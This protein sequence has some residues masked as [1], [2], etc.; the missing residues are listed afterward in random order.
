VWPAHTPRDHLRV[1]DVRR[2][3]L[4]WYGSLCSPN[5][6]QGPS[7]CIAVSCDVV[8]PSKLSCAAAEIM[9]TLPEDT[10]EIISTTEEGAVRDRV[11]A[12]FIVMAAHKDSLDKWLVANRSTVRFDVA[13]KLCKQF[14]DVRAVV[15]VCVCVCVCCVL[16]VC[17]VVLCC[18][19]LCCVVLC[20]L[21][22]CVCVL[23]L[24]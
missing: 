7:S 22:V 17:C 10:V 1:H 6:P 14:G 11:S 24:S 13:S 18:V 21:C 19:V 12:R 3:D 20:V 23:T 9:R 16:C 15:C 8:S 2:H 4:A 5:N